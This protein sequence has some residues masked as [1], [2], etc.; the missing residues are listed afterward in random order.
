MKIVAFIPYWFGYNDINEVKKLG[1]RYLINY[2]LEQ[3]NNCDL[4]DDVVLYSSDERIMDYVEDRELIEFEKRPKFLDSHEIKIEQIIEE[5]LKN[6][7]ADIVIL[8]HPNS[9]FL[10]KITISECIEKVLNNNYDSSF[11][12][13]KFNK[14]AWFKNKPLNYSTNE[15]TPHLKDIDPIVLELSSLYVF[16][17]EMFQ[18]THR[19]I[20]EKPF[21]KFIDHFEG[22][23][24]NNKEDFEMAE[25][26]VNSGMY[27]KAN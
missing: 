14:L 23:D 27:P 19:R 20:G 24:I 17:K 8:I 21:I 13:Y 16:R 26:I 1:G 25:L 12:A 10:S 18:N 4:I 2:T 15:K 3:L 11:I 5:F 22:H 6:S 7:D 9:P